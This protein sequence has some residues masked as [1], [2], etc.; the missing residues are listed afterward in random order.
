[1][2]TAA[3]AAACGE[4]DRRGGVDPAVGELVGPGC[5]AG[6][7]MWPPRLPQPCKAVGTAMTAHAE[8][9]VLRWRAGNGGGGGGAREDA[10]G[11]GLFVLRK[12]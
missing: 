6:G 5:D 10:T 3:A 8:P 2:R 9:G 12:P 1:M 11:F 4:L 7:R